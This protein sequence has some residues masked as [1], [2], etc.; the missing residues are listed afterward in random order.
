MLSHLK[1]ECTAHYLCIALLDSTY[2]KNTKPRRHSSSTCEPASHTQAHAVAQRSATHL[3]ADELFKLLEQERPHTLHHRATWVRKGGGGS[4]RLL[5]RRTGGEEAE[6]D[7]SAPLDLRPSDICS[8]AAGL[9]AKPSPLPPL[10]PPPSL[11]RSC[12]CCCCILLCRSSRLFFASAATP[13]S[14]TAAA[15]SASGGSA[16][17]ALVVVVGGGCS[18]AVAVQRDQSWQ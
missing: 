10:L 5:L 17:A 6:D 7:P 18:C 14:S 12:F 11:S 15:L 13:S 4:F 8:A 16:A 3:S 1:N 9:S 2:M